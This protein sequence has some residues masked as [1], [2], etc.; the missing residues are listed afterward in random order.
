[1]PSPDLRERLGRLRSAIV[2]GPDHLSAFRMMPYAIFVYGPREEFDLRL[3]LR[4]VFANLR[5]E[6]LDPIHLSLAE[7][8]HEAVARAQTEDGGWKG[9][10]AGERRRKSWRSAV[11][12]VQHVLSDAV[13]LSSMVIE[14]LAK[15]DP[16]RT[17]AF[18]GR[19]GALVPAYRPGAL[20]ARLAGSLPTQM[21]L[22]YPGRRAPDGSLVLLDDLPSDASTYARIF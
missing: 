7:I 12:T 1:M 10:Y 14:R 22:L 5:R 13:Q 8:A 20:L 11:Q 6:G 2:A 4:T 17:V 19:V 18:L 16:R 21:V 9:I 3:E 15:A